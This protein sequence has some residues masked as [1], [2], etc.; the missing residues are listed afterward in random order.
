[1][2][3][4]VFLLSMTLLLVASGTNIMKAQ[5]SSGKKML[6]A[7]YSWSGN[8]REIANQ[9]KSLT[10][11]DIFEIVPEK[12]YSTNYNE[13]VETAKNEINAGVKPALKTKVENI[14]QYDVIF[15]GT[16]NWW[17]TM[18]P[19]VATFLSDYDLSGKTLIPFVT[20]GGGGM[21]RC[22]SDMKQL[23]PDITFLKGIA[24]SG[25]R[26]K[27]AENKVA[28]WLKGIKIIE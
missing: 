21:A 19:P 1:M 24:I 22:E 26:A 6:V 15:V 3:S 14:E 25:S 7:Y 8:T 9:I 12:A 2:K 5:N 4:K 13:C 27:N 28:E 10:G 20:H 18:A 17:S 23:L 16:P 11:C